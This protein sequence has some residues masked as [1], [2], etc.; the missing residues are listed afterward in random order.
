MRPKKPSV[1]TLEMNPTMATAKTMIT[2][3][4]TTA[5]AAGAYPRTAPPPPPP[6]TT[7]ARVTATTSAALITTPPTTIT[8]EN[9]H[10]ARQP[11]LRPVGQ[12]KKA[13]HTLTGSASTAGT[14]RA[15]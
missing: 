11:A 5:A 3:T 13:R 1:I 10:E 4:T 14:D 7:T 6:A 8:N 15:C 9:T 2:V 12:W